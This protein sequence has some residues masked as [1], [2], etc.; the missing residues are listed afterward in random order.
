MS[1]MPAKKIK[2]DIQITA[3]RKIDSYEAFFCSCAFHF[4]PCSWTIHVTLHFYTQ[5]GGSCAVIM[6]ALLCFDAVNESKARYKHWLLSVLVQCGI[7]LLRHRPPLI[8]VCN[9][10]SET[11]KLCRSA[12]VYHWFLHQQRIKALPST[13]EFH[14]ISVFLN[15]TSSVGC[16]SDG[17]YKNRHTSAEFTLSVTWL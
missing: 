7:K 13:R 6:R 10:R 14:C 3:I 9:R 1:H 8:P 16:Q 15:I 12:V 17:T 5:Y 2:P 11:L 4:W